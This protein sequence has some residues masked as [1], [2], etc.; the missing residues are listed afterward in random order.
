MGSPP[1]S[2]SPAVTTLDPAAGQAGLSRGHQKKPAHVGLAKVSGS[3][4][5]GGRGV[6]A[7]SSQSRRVGDSC[8][9]NQTI[10]EAQPVVRGV[11]T[12]TPRG[13][14]GLCHHCGPGR[15]S[16][17]ARWFW[18]SEAHKPGV[19]SSTDPCPARKE[20]HGKF[21]SFS[22]SSSPFVRPGSRGEAPAPFAETPEG[23]P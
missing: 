6:G 23:A 9:G 4:G 13:G 18:A 14:Q 21:T 7:T 19:F 10:R 11:P 3:N 8:A 15:L 2:R 17:G 5:P 22:T 1:P 16:G 12:E 20:R